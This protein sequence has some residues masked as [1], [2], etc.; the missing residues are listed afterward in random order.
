M[1]RRALLYAA[2]LVGLAFPS[3]AIAGSACYDAKIRA[4]PVDQIP[5]EAGDCGSDCIIMSWPWFVDLEV[6]RVIDGTLSTKLVRVQTV[7]HTYSVSRET[8]W[9]LRRNAAGDYNVLIGEDGSALARCPAD[10][11]PVE[12]YIRPGDGNT[13]DDLRDTGIRRY[14]HHTN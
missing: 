8:T 7:Q 9:L 6:E 3:T 1:I 11:A 14:G 4:R 13:L 2:T 5:S 10:A 12:A